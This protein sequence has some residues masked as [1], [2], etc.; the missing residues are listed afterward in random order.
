MAYKM[1]LE[2]KNG[3]LTLP[4]RQSFL[5]NLDNVCQIKKKRPNFEQYYRINV[6]GPKL[7]VCETTSTTVLLLNSAF[8]TKDNVFQVALDDA[9]DAFNATLIDFAY[10]QKLQRYNPD[11]HQVHG[12][13]KHPFWSNK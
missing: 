5:K 13:P 1:S 3:T 4:T 8:T 12:T 6:D 2:I 10:T 11:S 7:A 9:I